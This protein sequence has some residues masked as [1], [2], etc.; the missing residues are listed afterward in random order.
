VGDRVIPFS[1][2]EALTDALHARA[3]AAAAQTAADPVTAV[4]PEGTPTA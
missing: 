4:S 2:V 1:D 3:A